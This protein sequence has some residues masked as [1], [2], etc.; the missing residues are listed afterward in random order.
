MFVVFS[1][2]EK[3][4]SGDGRKSFFRIFSKSFFRIFS[5]VL[6]DGRL[7]TFLVSQKDLYKEKRIPGDGRLLVSFRGEE[8]RGYYPYTL[9]GYR[10]DFSPDTTPYEKKGFFSVKEKT[11]T[12][13]PRRDTYPEGVRDTTPKGYVSFLLPKRSL[14][15]TKRHEKSFPE[16]IRGI[17]VQRDLSRIFS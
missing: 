6:V 12:P 2:G 17:E 9:T 15:L 8:E 10:G 4:I 1:I 7:Q 14:S 3:R 11:C 16:K 13:I 5:V